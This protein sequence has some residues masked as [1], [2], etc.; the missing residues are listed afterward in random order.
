MAKMPPVPPEQR[1]VTQS[2]ED[3]AAR[4]NSAHPDRRDLQTCV[5]SGQPGDED[6]DLEKQGRF[7]NIAQ[8]VQTQWKTQ[9]R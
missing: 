5:Q 9:D 8:N 7:G 6:V 2:P 3:P 1:S 4:L